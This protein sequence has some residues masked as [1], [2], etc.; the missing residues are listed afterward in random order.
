MEVFWTGISGLDETQAR[1]PGQSR[2]HGSA[3]GVSLL[4]LAVRE[5]WGIDLP[6]LAVQENGKPY[7]PA[8][9]DLHFS[10]SHTKTAVLAALSAHPVGA[11]VEQRRAV[12]ATT[13]RIL[14]EVPCGDLEL[15]ELWTLRESYYKLTGRGSLR[16]IP[17][18][19]E[20]GILIPPEPGVRCRVY[21]EVPGCAAAVCSWVEEPPVRLQFVESMRICT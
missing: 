5:V 2:A 19:R 13:A 18:S 1:Y 6:E 4:A 20:N 10:I 8:Y 14:T 3:F 7:F 21:D 15:F 12:R 17:F 16:S 9:P 11:D